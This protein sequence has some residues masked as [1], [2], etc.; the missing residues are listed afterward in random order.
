MRADEF[1]HVSG[2][3]SGE[4]RLTEMRILRY[5]IL[6]TDIQIGKVASPAA[7]DDDLSPNLGIVFDDEDAFPT[8]ARLNSAE[9]PRSTAADD[10]RVKSH[11][12]KNSFFFSSKI[13]RFSRRS[14]SYSN[15]VLIVDSIISQSSEV[16]LI[17]T[18]STSGQSR[19]R[20]AIVFR[21][22]R[23]SAEQI[24]S[25]ISFV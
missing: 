21:M 7:R 17:S 2:T 9:Q 5:E 3:I 20:P 6:R 25:D 19:D 1:D 16:C 18:D 12:R 8:P 10:D 22:I 14:T 15:R 11:G 13:S 23:S 4:C 24:L